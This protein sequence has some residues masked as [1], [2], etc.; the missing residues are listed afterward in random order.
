MYYLLKLYNSKIFL[1]FVLII[2]FIIGLLFGFN[3][4]EKSVNKVIGIMPTTK[5]LRLGYN[6]SDLI[7]PLLAC[8]ISESID[9]AEL[10]PLKNKINNYILEQ[11]TL[12]LAN[13]VSVYYRNLNDGHWTGVDEN[14]KFVAASLIKVPLLMAYMKKAQAE[15]KILEQ[16]YTYDKDDADL[17]QEV[18]KPPTPF[19]K[20]K[21]YSINELL[22]RMIAYSGNNS[23][24]VLAQAI[25]RDFLKNV[26]DDLGLSYSDFE[27]SNGVDNSISPK[28]FATF[29]RI[30]YNA[31]YLNYE[32]S[33]KALELM[34]NSTFKDGL[35]AGL[36]TD[37]KVAR[38]FGERT[39]HD[40]ATGKVYF[41]ELHDCGIIYNSANPYLLCVMTQGDN[42]NNLK[43]VIKNISSLVYND[44]NKK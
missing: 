9:F 38:K 43:V 20:G 40:N 22:Y 31:T 5:Q 11:K 23:H 8:D 7:N 14:D 10:A 17:Q 35:A 33:K 29:F 2:I 37:M 12:G 4:K 15:P 42:F 36:P 28:T 30:L 44:L 1:F 18:Q 6:S 24:M 13:R 34:V 27:L 41:R 25:D 16:T 26:Y 32:Y 39:V 19:V 3:L 21:A